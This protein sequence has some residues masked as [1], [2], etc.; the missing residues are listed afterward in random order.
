MAELSRQQATIMMRRR[1]RV[2]P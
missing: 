2:P 1:Y